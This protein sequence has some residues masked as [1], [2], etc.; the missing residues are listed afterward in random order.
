M[1]RT[2][3]R[4]CQSGRDWVLLAIP[5]PFRQSCLRASWQQ[6][7]E[8]NRRCSDGPV[9]ARGHVVLQSAYGSYFIFRYLD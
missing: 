1:E 2:G 8:G 4:Q 5:H 3:L 7:D 6:P 9:V